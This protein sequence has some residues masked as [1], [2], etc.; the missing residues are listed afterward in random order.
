MATI[1]DRVSLPARRR[2]LGLS[3]LGLIL[4]CFLAF[5]GTFAQDPAES[6]RAEAIRVAEAPAQDPSSQELGLQDPSLPEVEP[7]VAA[8]PEGGPPGQSG[9]D[10]SVD[11]EAASEE[12]SQTADTDSPEI[13]RETTL[14]FFKPAPGHLNSRPGTALEQIDRDM[15]RIVSR[16]GRSVVRVDSLGAL[17]DGADPLA[18]RVPEHFSGIVFDRGLVVTVADAL[19]GTERIYVKTFDGRQYPAERV[20]VDELSGVAVLHVPNAPLTPVDSP[21]SVQ[22]DVGALALTIGNP[23]GLTTTPSLGMLSGI[24]T[25]RLRQEQEPMLQLSAA[26]N[27]GDY[28][29][30]VADASGV[31]IGM[32]V[33]SFRVR[34][35]VAPSAEVDTLAAFMNELERLRESG[36][37]FDTRD[38]FFEWLDDRARDRAEPTSVA[39]RFHIDKG[40]A[41]TPEADHIHFAMPFM[42]VEEIA[43][44]IVARSRSAASFAGDPSGLLADAMTRP[45][46]GVRV[47]PVR[48]ATTGNRV[49]KNDRPRAVRGLLVLEVIE[50]GPA[51]LAGLQ[52]RDVITRFNGVELESPERFDGVLRSVPVGQPASIDVLRGGKLMRLAVT[53]C[54][55]PNAAPRS[56]PAPVGASEPSDAKTRGVPGKKGDAGA[57]PDKQRRK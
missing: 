26:V 57:D 45:W 13:R 23:F 50:T 31:V 51:A 11:D 32:I 48:Y 6:G 9:V 53:L 36:E 39:P 33:S 42:R 34:D 25:M 1:S 55:H 38:A 18:R 35:H 37:P 10:E 46:I 12:G 28:G 43:H 30:I 24:R 21:R 8:R 3:T 29:G 16:L 44:Q 15:R 5:P 40:S 56:F 54:P 41:D 20:G 27:P 2:V 52:R 17:E 19:A 49:Q 14:R 22:L 47:L 7:G 4:A